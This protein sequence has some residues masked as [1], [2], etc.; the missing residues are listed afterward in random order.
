MS[1][2]QSKWVQNR[3]LSNLRKDS[4]EAVCTNVS[5]LF[6]YLLDKP[7][8]CQFQCCK[9]QK[10]ACDEGRRLH[11]MR[12]QKI[13]PYFH[14]SACSMLPWQPTPTIC[15]RLDLLTL[16]SDFSLSPLLLFLP[17]SSFHFPLLLKFMKFASSCEARQVCKLSLASKRHDGWLLFRVSRRWAHRCPISCK[18]ASFCSDRVTSNSRTS[19]Q[20][21]L[22]Q[23]KP[24][25]ASF[26]PSVHYHT[27]QVADGEY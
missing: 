3:Q 24:H 26:S 4:V 18:T 23:S 7:A 5:K 21:W 27:G 8:S 25:L 19:R 13:M 17:F 2:L 12:A 6:S 22:L 16:S 11:L 20:A 15:A 10:R 9:C 1:S 14:C